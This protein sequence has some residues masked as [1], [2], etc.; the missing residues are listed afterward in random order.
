MISHLNEKNKPKIVD[1]SKK[2]ITTRIAVAESTVQFSKLT[3]KKIESLMGRQSIYFI[4]KKYDV[5]IYV[6]AVI[7]NSYRKRYNIPSILY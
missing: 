6:I 7:W 4:S 2:K 3:F 1:I 5:S